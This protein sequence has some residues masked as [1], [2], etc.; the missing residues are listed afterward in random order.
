MSKTYFVSGQWNVI[1]DVCSKK[2]KAQDTK[3]RWDG[4]ITCPSCFEYRHPQDFVRATIDNINVPFTRP[5]PP[6]VFVEVPYICTIDG[7]TAIAGWA[8]AG[9]SITGTN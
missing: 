3:Q 4:F 7:R 8:V 9:C 1:C 6:D 2:V 5:R